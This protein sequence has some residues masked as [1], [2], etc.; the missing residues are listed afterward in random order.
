MARHRGRIAEDL[1]I[2]LVGTVAVVVITPGNDETAT[3]QAK[4]I[5]LVRIA[6]VV[7]SVDAGIAID[8]RTIGGKLLNISTAVVIPGYG[9]AAVGQRGDRR[10]ILIAADF[11]I[12]AEFIAYLVAAGIKTL[13]EDTGRTTILAVG[14]PHGDKVTTSETNHIAL[15]LGAIGICVHHE[16]ST[17][18]R[19]IGGEAL[20]EDTVAVTVGTVVGP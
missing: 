2:N 20:A 10:L 7:D 1:L 6:V 16:C 14:T 18:C 4:H 19:T 9:E 3:I 17:G 15:I 13:G 11:A 5:G 8:P 12:D